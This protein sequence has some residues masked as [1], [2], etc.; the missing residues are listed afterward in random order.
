MGWLFTQGQTKKELIHRLT[1]REENDSGI[2]ET[3]AHC[4][5]GNVLWS[6]SEFTRKDTGEIS[7]TILCYLMEKQKDYGWGYKD[8]EESMSPNYYSCPLKYL[9]MA[10]IRNVG[11]RNCVREYH[12]DRNR[13]MGD[14]IRNRDKA[15]IEDARVRVTLRGTTLEYIWLSSVKPLRGIGPDGMMYRLRRKH[16]GES[17]LVAK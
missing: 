6:V 3:L 10:P 11:W 5:R 7:K 1:D 13:Y 15:E 12:A 4:V 9:D 14:L 16:I 8:I 17:V 2:W